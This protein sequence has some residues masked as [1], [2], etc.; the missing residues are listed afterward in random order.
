MR[1]SSELAKWLR[2]I[3]TAASQVQHSVVPPLPPPPIWKSQARPHGWS[4]SSSQRTLA[5]Q[6]PSLGRRLPTSSSSRG[7]SSS[8]RLSTPSQAATGQSFG[9]LD[10]SLLSPPQA[11]RVTR[12]KAKDVD[13]D[14]DLL[15]DDELEQHCW[16]V[17]Q[18]GLAHLTEAILLRFESR[19]SGSTT[20]A[21]RPS[22]RMA[23]QALING[24]ADG[25]SLREAL[26]PEQL[27]RSH[28]LL[29]GGLSP[30]EQPFRFLGAADSRSLLS[31]IA[32][33]KQLGLKSVFTSLHTQLL[34]DT[35]ISD[36]PSRSELADISRYCL[37]EP[38]RQREGSQI[39]KRSLDRL[40]L[41]SDDR[42]LLL[43]A[44][45]DVRTWLGPQAA[46]DDVFDLFAS[47]MGVRLGLQE[48]H[49][50]DIEKLCQQIIARF[51]PLAVDPTAPARYVLNVVQVLLS[52]SDQTAKQR[53]SVITQAQKLLLIFSDQ[54]I[55][56]IKS[57][58]LQSNDLPFTL[59]C[60]QALRN[61]Q[62]NKLATQVLIEYQRKGV[63]LSD[64]VGV[65]MLL[66]VI[67]RL[68]R[69]RETASVAVARELLGNLD[70]QSLPTDTALLSLP[71]KGMNLLLES[72]AHL[73]L[74]K[75]AAA[76]WTCWTM[77][78]SVDGELLESNAGTMREMVKL[79]A[80][81]GGSKDASEAAQQRRF[82]RSVLE[83]F[84]RRKDLLD[85][86]R[87]ELNALA[88]AYEYLGDRREAFNMIHQLLHRREIPNELDLL[89]V[90][91]AVARID[92]TKA[93]DLY[94]RYL[95]SR[96]KR[97]KTQSSG[98]TLFPGIRATPAVVELLL[99][100]AFAVAST[101]DLKR[102]MGIARSENVFESGSAYD[103]L[104]KTLSK[105][106]SHRLDWSRTA[107]SLRNRSDS[108]VHES[109]YPTSALSWFIAASANSISIGDQLS[110][111]SLDSTSSSPL[112]PDLLASID[113]LELAMTRAYTI[114]A[115][116]VDLLLAR[117]RQ[118]GRLL[119]R[120]SRKVVEDAEKRK[121]E[122]E[123][124]KLQEGVDRVTSV[125]RRMQKQRIVRSM[126]SSETR[127]V[128]LEPSKPGEED[129]EEEDKAVTNQDDEDDLI[130]DIHPSN[131]AASSDSS[132]T[133]I[134]P[135]A[136][137]LHP[138]LNPIVFQNLIHLYLDVSDVD[139]ASEVY[140][141]MKEA[142]ASYSDDD[143][144]VT[145][146]RL[147][148]R[149]EKRLATIL[150]DGYQEVLQNGNSWDW[151]GRR[152]E[153]KKDWWKM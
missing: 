61:K 64:L 1:R 85:C 21:L 150:G 114:N 148:I 102:L 57:R 109:P 72:L 78:P 20:Q 117:L 101:P 48:G 86:D 28:Q 115:A 98:A 106:L 75:P 52:A 84:L 110:T 82:A 53:S 91:R 133:P 44:S 42:S 152:I 60:Q 145:R 125:L 43:Q 122:N 139:G 104:L 95:A 99:S 58:A 8:S 126:D 17:G 2:A 73:R 153:R 34:A 83:A 142:L 3:G 6:H 59:F 4:Y 119:V 105:G 151:R 65:S 47:C 80:T 88:S 24:A 40:V 113:M 18:A 97:P 146:P 33:S 62:V 46:G 89:F 100:N 141:W 25:D 118:Y 107:R 108:A 49:R 22:Q 131:G 112:L 90:F 135:T 56:L 19:P 29:Q 87:A 147:A 39:L 27:L 32:Q 134:I 23:L 5:S 54:I 74:K 12:R 13:R 93:T 136:S 16:V 10:T 11:G 128:N 92:V 124:V 26:T 71:V 36:F 111:R 7:F 9:S 149:L 116:V 103:F 70:A 127:G 137:P 45:A 76:L 15:H 66:R 69:L 67:Y 129:W 41:R 31:R 14:L 143:G 50:D 123:R 81:A 120:R 77:S 130:L 138:L 55:P 30:G 144:L 51:T 63:S 37:T 132:N 96:R 140:E 35:D 121:V 38:F 94:Q 79:F 68:G